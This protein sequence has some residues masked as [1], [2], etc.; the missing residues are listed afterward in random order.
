LNGRSHVYYVYFQPT[1]LIGNKFSFQPRS[2]H[3]LCKWINATLEGHAFFIFQG[4]KL[5]T[6]QAPLLTHWPLPSD[7]ATFKGPYALLAAVAKN[8][9]DGIFLFSYTKFSLSPRED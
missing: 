2:N 4:C 5:Y 3:I 8:D 7:A 1:A 6:F 9:Y